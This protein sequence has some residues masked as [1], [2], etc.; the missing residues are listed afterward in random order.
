MGLILIS[1]LLAIILGSCVWL[2][3]GNSFPLRKAEKWP[4]ANNIFVYALV[5][6]VPIYLAIFFM[7]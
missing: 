7:F 4:I 2:L 5:L 6:V 3:V 1:T